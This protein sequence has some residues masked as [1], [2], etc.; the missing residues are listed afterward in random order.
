[1]TP[2]TIL[3]GFAAG[4]LLMLLGCH[5]PGSHQ[6]TVSESTRLDSVAL[7][8]TLCF[9]TCPAY[10]VSVDR[11]G[12]VRFALRNPGDAFA[13][14]DTV[15]NATVDS[16][17]ALATRTGFYSLPDSINRRSATFCPDYATDHPSIIVFLYGR[18]PKTVHYYTGC[19]LRSDHTAH[20]ALQDL[21][22]LAGIIDSATGAR[23]WIRPARRR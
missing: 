7:E 15:A 19:Y 4:A 10:R 3:F 2:R 22:R 13:A 20:A 16:I 12:L 5:A 9:G 1:M 18:P 23:R 17:Y 14:T 11:G 6:S 21:R 8:R